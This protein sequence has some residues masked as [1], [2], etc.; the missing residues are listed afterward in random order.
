MWSDITQISIGSNSW[1]QLDTN[2]ATRDEAFTSSDRRL[3]FML[4]HEGGWNEYAGRIEYRSDG[5]VEIYNNNWERVA[6][7][8]DL[9][10]PD[11]LLEVVRSYSCYINGLC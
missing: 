3:S 5:L 8:V 9:S 4:K 6:R 1:S 10:I 2:G 11:N 7:T